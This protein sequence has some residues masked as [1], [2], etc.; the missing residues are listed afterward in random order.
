MASIERTAYPRFKP[1][2]NRTELEQ[3]YRPNEDEFHFVRHHARGERQQLTLLVLLKTHQHL[4]YTPP[5]KQVPKPVVH[6]LAEGLGLTG[7]P[8][9]EPETRR[10]RT[11]FYRYRLAIRALLGIDSWSQGGEDIARH[12]IEKAAHTMSD[13]ADLINVAIETLIANRF[14]LPAFSALDRLVGHIREL[15]H[16]RQYEQ[17]TSRLTEH[18]CHRLDA[19]L[20]V[21]EDERLTDFNR[22][23]QA[24]KK[25]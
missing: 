6:Y 5:V 12:A 23:K 14:E 24:P 4:G 11:R 15:V 22:I 25:A 3:L 17:I 2:L 18:Q 13:P 9:M 7:E 1:N 16:L 19:L 10:T 21:R 8:M 20:E